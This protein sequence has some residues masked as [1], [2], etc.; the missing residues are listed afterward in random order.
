M[1]SALPLMHLKFD[2]GYYLNVIMQ[3]LAGTSFVNWMKLLAEN[4]FAIDWQFIPRALYVTL[5][6]FGIAPFRLYEKIKFEKK[7]YV[8]AAFHLEKAVNSRKSWK[9]ARRL[10]AESYSMLGNRKKAMEH[11]KQVLRVDPEDSLSLHA[12]GCLYGEKERN[13]EVA[14]SLCEKAVGFDEKNKKYRLD[15]A[16]LLFQA[17]DLRGALAQLDIILADDNFA[18]IES[19]VEEGRGIYDLSLIH[20]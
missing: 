7:D 6:I 10:L 12:L 3:P 11:Y 9:A 20:I 4:R 2:K 17:G 18:T 15:L 19:A 5:M 1:K 13:L 8:N 14:I 16:R